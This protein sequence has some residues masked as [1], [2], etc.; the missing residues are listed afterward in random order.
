MFSNIFFIISVVF[1]AGLLIIRFVDFLKDLSLE[2][3]KNKKS[4]KSFILLFFTIIVLLTTSYLL[5]KREFSFPSNTANPKIPYYKNPE[6]WNDYN[7]F[8]DKNLT[9]FYD[10]HF[11]I[12]NVFFGNW[13]KIEEVAFEI[14]EV[15]N[16][17]EIMS[18]TDWL[19][20]NNDSIMTI[21]T[22]NSNSEDTYRYYFNADNKLAKIESRNST[23]NYNYNP[24][25]RFMEYTVFSN[26]TLVEKHTVT[27]NQGHDFTISKFDSSGILFEEE[28]RE[29]DLRGFLKKVSLREKVSTQS[30]F[31]FVSEKEIDFDKTA[32]KNFH[33]QNDKQEVNIKYLK[34]NK[35]EKLIYEKGFN[36]LILQPNWAIGEGSEFIESKYK[37]DKNDNWIIYINY[38]NNIAYYLIL[39]KFTYKD[40]TVTG[41][42]DPDN[43]QMRDSIKEL[44]YKKE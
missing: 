39:R 5:I 43:P 20:Y 26:R 25:G 42:I 22:N 38:V 35:E 8:R 1:I 44:L 18:K 23:H 16:G 24:E 36:Q 7:N 31:S 28:I 15:P 27:L 21:R 6:F 30:P 11:F 34:G 41:G 9:K 2:K 14:K 13:E 17:F 12:I 3:G 29:H 32:I 40:G 10:P 37:Y 33:F 19:T 4:R